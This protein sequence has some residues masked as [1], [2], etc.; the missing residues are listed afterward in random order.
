MKM[1]P[2][3]L[4]YD[5]GFRIIY[6]CCFDFVSLLYISHDG[7]QQRGGTSA[8]NRPAACIKGGIFIVAVSD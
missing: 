4:Y 2:K 7:N 5:T 1:Y 6:K 3:P 8:V